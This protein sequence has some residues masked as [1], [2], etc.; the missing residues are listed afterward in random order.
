MS[1]AELV[2]HPPEGLG[3][4]VHTRGEGRELMTNGLVLTSPQ[5]PH[6]TGNRRKG[7]SRCAESERTWL[8]AAC[9]R[10]EQF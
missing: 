6:W 1:Q 2:L 9:S 7:R 5:W 4:G 10:S 3:H 8:A